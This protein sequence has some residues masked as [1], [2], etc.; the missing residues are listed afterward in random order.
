MSEV[1]KDWEGQVI[2][3]KYRLQSLIGSTDHSVVFLAEYRNPEPREAAVKFV[4]ADVPNPEQILAAWDSAA[5]LTH[6]NLLRILQSGK[7]KIDD[8]E[9]L[10]VAMEYAEENLAGVVPQ[11]ALTAM[12]AREALN[13][14]VDVLVYLHDKELTHGH[15]CPANILA[16][17][18]LL[19]VSSDTIEPVAEKREM[20]RERSV[21]DAPEIPG[22]AYT[23]AADVWSLGVTMVTMLTQ[24]PPILPFNE[25]VDPVVPQN[26]PEPFA[27][28]AHHALRRKPEKRWTSA[29]IA[30]RLNPNRVAAKAAAA[31]AGGA[32]SQVT[33]SVV[34]AAA[35]PEV[36]AA[37]AQNAS[38]VTTLAGIPQAARPASVTVSPLNVP[39]SAE[40]AVPLTRQARV[41]ATPGRTAKTPHGS[42]RRETFV[43]PNYALPLFLGALIVA[44]GL[45]LPKIL[46]NRSVSAP[47]T[48]QSTAA[49][50]KSAS[51]EPAKPA[52]PPAELAASPGV[53][54]KD[55][56]KETA[57]TIE[58]PPARATEAPSAAPAVLR[59]Q[60][61][62]P[63]IRAKN[64]SETSERGEALDQPT[65]Q[66]S[67]KALSTIT[68]TVK[69]L[70]KAH[71]DASGQVTGAELQDPGPSRYFADKAVQAAQ[72]WVFSSPDVNGRSVASEWL[73]RFEYTRG[74]VKSFPQQ[75]TP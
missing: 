25:N 66:V 39:V 69:V 53:S 74:G 3:H 22:T 38:A 9:L 35:A 75:I 28:I 26:V 31:S 16:T 56:A 5:K 47:T 30:E 51:A 48:T 37:S 20:T 34:S 2:E 63:A 21:Y 32:I 55:E 41:P 11:R 27:E 14:V 15:I 73:I 57:K 1:W 40:P 62:S 71:V 18:D 46:H 13:A 64:S 7:C 43:L 45:A 24:Q 65:P 23:M 17:G 58:P 60:D 36:A 68:G 72:R 54:T 10:Y 33:P 8:R 49:P 42:A 4:A 50:A 6:P 29:Q 61:A 70:V 52:T 59:T 44:A 67:E 12:E 19:K